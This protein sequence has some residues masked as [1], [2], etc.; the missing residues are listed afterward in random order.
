MSEK[1]RAASRS[2][3]ARSR[4]PRTAVGKRNAS[5]NALRHGF[6]ALSHRNTVSDEI[7]EFARMLCIGDDNP[8]LFEPALVIAE[9]NILLGS[10]RAEGVA[11]VERLR[12]RTATA[13]CKRDTSLATATARADQIDLA[14]AELEKIY[15]RFGILCWYELSGE[16]MDQL[17]SEAPRLGWRPPLIE[18]RDECDA[19]MAA[20]PDLLR[21]ARYERRACS[22]R[23][24]AIEKFIKLR[25]MQF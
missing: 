19:L 9:N 10:I 6:A 11:V 1:K 20:I 15:A 2:N 4:G 12:D 14:G 17:E 24:R 16:Q 23:R 13:L 18:D 25:T 21:L 8:D 5:R 3:G 22:R 7:Y